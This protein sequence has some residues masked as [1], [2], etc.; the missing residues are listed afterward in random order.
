MI[1]ALKAESL[2]YRRSFAR[3]LVLIAPLFFILIALPQKI[4]MPSDYLRPWELLVDQVYNWWPIIFIPL[5]TALF[6]ALV[7]LQEKKAGNYRNLRVHEISPAVIWTGKAILMAYYTFFA[8]L[9]L[10]AATVITG[11][12]T[13]G[14]EIPW[15]KIFIGGVTLWITSLAVIPIQLWAATWKGTFFSMAVGVA[16]LIAGVLAAPTNYWIFVPWSWPTRLMCPI[17]GVH[18]NGVPLK[19]PDPLLS[20][21]V[22]PTGIILAVASFL[23]FTA[24]TALWFNKKEVK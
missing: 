14:G 10:I 23:T 8:T 2:K 16:G 20:S 3:R 17:V 18:P 12:I 24:I 1:N 15:I 4:Y 5:G 22:I 13:A 9:V 21:S 19:A 6:A 11:L 7:A